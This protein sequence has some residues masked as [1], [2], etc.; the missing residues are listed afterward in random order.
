MSRL[1][2]LIGVA[3]LA[4]AVSRLFYRHVIANIAVIVSLAA[5]IGMLV[6]AVLVGVC[7]IA[8]LSLVQHGFDA[9]AA[10]WIIG[11]TL[12]SVLTILIAAMLHRIHK[13]Q[14]ITS[15]FPASRA[16]RVVD[17]FMEGLTE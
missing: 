2:K 14:N 4:R 11:A 6:A 7:Y 1:E 3:V 16:S 9:A 17:A 10:G 12:F 8:Y 15:L 13:L 5:I